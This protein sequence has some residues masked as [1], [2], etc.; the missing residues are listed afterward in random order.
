MFDIAWSEIAVIL[1]V[2]FIVI[3]PKDIPVALRTVKGW[4]HKLQTAKQEIGALLHDISR[5]TELTGV[6]QQLQGQAAQINQTIRQIVDLEGNLRDAYDISDLRP[7]L[8]PEHNAA[9]T[10]APPAPTGAPLGMHVVD[11]YSMNKKTLH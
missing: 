3:G 1:V 4:M 8:K 7:D 2:A 9:S 5:E 6:Q 10:S 11:N